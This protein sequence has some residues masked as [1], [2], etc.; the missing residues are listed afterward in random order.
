MKKLGY[1]L[2]GAA[3]ASVGATLGFTYYN[4]KKLMGH[5]D[6]EIPKRDSGKLQKYLEPYA[7]MIFD[8]VEFLQ[9]ERCET[10]YTDSY[11]GLKLAAL[12]VPAEA[13]QAT[14]ILMHG[15]LLRWIS[16][17]R[18]RLGIMV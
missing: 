13:P 3:L 5:S 4:F 9:S 14:I 17:T 12:C 11:D 10:V 2:G 18:T 15:F 7:D 8:G 6:Y 16:S 1:V